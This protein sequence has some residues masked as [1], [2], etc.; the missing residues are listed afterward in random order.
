[1]ESIHTSTAAIKNKLILLCLSLCCIA[2]TAYIGCSYINVN[3]IS[4]PSSITLPE[5]LSPEKITSPIK[6]YQHI[7][8]RNETFSSVMQGFGLSAAQV[9]ELVTAAKPEHPLTK[10]KPG[11]TVTV[12]LNQASGDLLSLRH[13]IDVKTRLLVKKNLRGYQSLIQQVPLT[14]VLKNVSVQITSS[15]YEDGIKAGLSPRKIVE[16]TDIFPWDINF[17]TDLHEQDSF[18]VVYEDSS[19]DGRVVAEGKIL[20]A[21]ITKNGTAYQAFFFETTKGRGAYYDSSGKSLKKQF[22]KSPLRFSRITSGFTKKRFH[23]ILHVYR[24][25]YGIDYAAPQG[26]PVEAVADGVILFC[27]WKKGFGNFLKM[28]HGKNYA[29]S[30]GHLSGFARRARRG[31][32]V[33][34]GDV[35]GYVGATGC[36]TGPHLDFRLIKAGRPVNPLAVKNIITH[37]VKLQH[38]DSFK[39]TV[40]LRSAQ[41]SLESG[42]LTRMAGR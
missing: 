3:L 20:A 32:T 10:I 13:D 36:A 35:I 19:K 37:E 16:L 25:H 22:L 29:S 30:Y 38:M 21:E 28:R 40:H 41:L 9:S 7:Y 26:T 27:G 14:T 31:R 6:A 24:P 4:S 15:I 5:I 11:Q 1:M 42:T 33:K 23:P 8:K 18:K 39:K 17:F 2:L 34:Q 12:V